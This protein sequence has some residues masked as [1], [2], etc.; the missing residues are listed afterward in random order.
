MPANIAI[1]DQSYIDFEKY[2]GHLKKNYRPDLI[3]FLS[4]YTCWLG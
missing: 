3:F 2:H 4:S 1:S